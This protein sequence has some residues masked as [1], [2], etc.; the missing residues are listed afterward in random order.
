MS[1]YQRILQDAIADYDAIVP[2]DID[3]RIAALD[4]A[5]ASGNR[6]QI[7]TAFA[8][9][10]QYYTQLSSVITNLQT[11]LTKASTYVADSQ[12]RLINEERYDDRVHPEESTKARE[13]MY[14][15]FPTL[16]TSSLPYLLAASVFMAS[17]SI[18]IVFQLGG[19][20]G[21][22]NLPPSLIQALYSAPAT[23]P[24]YRNP[25]VLSGVIIVLVSAVIIFDYLYFKK[26]ANASK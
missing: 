9:I 6:P 18:F 15:L 25:M 12:Y 26:R 17:L 11:Y 3:A 14:G 22:F 8:P 20:S 19:L 5:L 7:E 1:G 10:S 13:I 2:I 4:S 16:R 21:Q 24:F 23:V